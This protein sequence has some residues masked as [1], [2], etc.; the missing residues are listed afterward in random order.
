[1]D[2]ACLSKSS[3]GSVSAGIRENGANSIS[4]HLSTS[5]RTYTFHAYLTLNEAGWPQ[6]A[7][8]LKSSSKSSWEIIVQAVGDRVFT[9]ST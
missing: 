1:M 8:L 4:E 9:R 5:A 6:G 3:K 2:R 7:R